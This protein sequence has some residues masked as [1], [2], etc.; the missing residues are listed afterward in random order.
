MLTP[1]QEVTLASADAQGA[2]DNQI[3]LP[4]GFQIAPSRRYLVRGNGSSAI[5]RAQHREDREA[6]ARLSPRRTRDFGGAG[7]KVS[8][9]HIS[10]PTVLLYNGG[11]Q[12]ASAVFAVTFV[13]TGL[14]AYA[15]FVEDGSDGPAGGVLKGAFWVLVAGAALALFNLLD[16]YSQT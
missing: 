15:V 16:R 4:A 1:R 3:L 14:L 9:R 12:L 13:G 8:I 5:L 10:Y 11:I 6:G 2:A 7:A